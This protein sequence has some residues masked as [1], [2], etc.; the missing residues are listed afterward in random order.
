MIT[1]LALVGEPLDRDRAC[2]LAH[3]LPGRLVAE[4]PM[5]PVSQL[6]VIPGSEQKTSSIV[7][8]E[9]GNPADSA[10]K[11]RQATS[12]GLEVDQARCLGPD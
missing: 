7:L 8:D 10:S 1:D 3:Q 6:P 12:Q 4:Q 2:P 11:D 5:E 9:F